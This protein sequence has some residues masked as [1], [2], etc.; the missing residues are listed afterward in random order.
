[1]TVYPPLAIGAGGRVAHGAL[2]LLAWGIAAGFVAGV[3][4]KPSNRWLR[5][6][7]G[8]RAALTMMAAGAVVLASPRLG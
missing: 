8:A 3:G 7:L 4:F 2:L 5:V 6:A 1:L